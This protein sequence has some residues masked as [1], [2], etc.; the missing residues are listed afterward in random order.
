MFVK[1][2]RLKKKKRNYDNDENKIPK[3]RK[4]FYSK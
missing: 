4:L 1:N 2:S 3:S